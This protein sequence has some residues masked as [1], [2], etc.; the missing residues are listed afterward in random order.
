M[1]E[2]GRGRRRCGKG[3]RMRQNRKKTVTNI[4]KK[5]FKGK[6]TI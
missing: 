6:V 3:R 2:R 4:K 1:K 5:L